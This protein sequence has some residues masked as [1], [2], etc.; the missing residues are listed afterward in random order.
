MNMMNEASLMSLV[1]VPPLNLPRP[2]EKV[3]KHNMHSH[4]RPK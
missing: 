3:Q 1:N 2:P 4:V